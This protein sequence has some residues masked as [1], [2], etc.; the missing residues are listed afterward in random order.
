MSIGHGMIWP[1]AAEYARRGWAVR[2]AGWSNGVT[3]P[4][5]PA[6][7]MRWIIFNSGLFHLTF[8]DRGDDYLIGPVTRVVRNTDFGVDEFYADDWTVFS[9]SCSATPA[10]DQ[11]GKL[12][13]PAAVDD[14]PYTDPTG[15]EAGDHGCPDVPP[16]FDDPPPYCGGPCQPP[17]YCG[18]NFKLATGGYDSCGCRFHVCQPIFCAD[19]QTCPP[20]TTLRIGGYNDLGCAIWVCAPDDRE[21]CGDPPFCGPNTKLALSGSNVRGCPTF[22]CQPIGCG[23][24]PVCSPGQ[25]LTATGLDNAGCPLW[26]CAP[27]DEQPCKPCLDFEIL[28]QPDSFL[29]TSGPDIC[30]CMNKTCRKKDCPQ[31]PLCFPGSTLLKV[32][33][34]ANGCDLFI[35]QTTPPPPDDEGNGGGGNGGGGGGGGG[36]GPRPRRPPPNLDPA[37]I[38]IENVTWTPDCFLDDTAPPF[39]IQ[40]GFRVRLGAAPTQFANGLYWISVY[41]HGKKID[42]PSWT[43]GTAVDYSV[44]V[45]QDLGKSVLIR[46]NAYL[47]IKR[48]QS[49]ARHEFNFPKICVSGCTNP[50]AANYDPEITDDDGSC[51]TCAS[52][53]NCIPYDTDQGQNCND[54]GNGCCDGYCETAGDCSPS[55]RRSF[56][57][58]NGTYYPSCFG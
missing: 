47:P 51:I 6:T 26:V 50:H 12:W 18:P 28:C 46:A 4:F 9:P 53:G 21:P 45:Q 17:P 30:G 43:P 40:L 56:T 58:E 8:F 7:S 19:P 41:V 54:A 24:P 15:P 1:L 31:P 23:D 37:Q 2:R 57:A 16:I 10:P 33:T 49:N 5:N 32:G 29:V 38:I 35:C 42:A 34:D 22:V 14:E 48:I 20:G 44:A 3:R 11:Q 39:Q 52:A 36:G 27:N 25:S 13:Y 55:F